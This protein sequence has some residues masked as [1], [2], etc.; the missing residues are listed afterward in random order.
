MKE[1]E[2]KTRRNRTG[3]DIGG[4]KETGREM[5]EEPEERN[6]R[7]GNDRRGCRGKETE[8]QEGMN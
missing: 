4:R 7:T 6:N 1:E 8:E 2:R 5:K 3:Y